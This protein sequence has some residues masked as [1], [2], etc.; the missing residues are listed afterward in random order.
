MQ[1]QAIQELL[2]LRKRNFESAII[3]IGLWAICVVGFIIS[4]F[5]IAPVFIYVFVIVGIACFALALYCLFSAN[6]AKIAAL[7]CQALTKSD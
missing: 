7:Q 2:A 1:N 3:W 6:H 5:Q 4:A